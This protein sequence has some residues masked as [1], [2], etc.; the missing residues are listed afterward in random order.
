MYFPDRA[1]LVLVLGALSLCCNADERD[2]CFKSEVEDHVLKQ[3]AVHEPLSTDRETFGFIFRADGLISSAVVRGTRCA[4]REVCEVDTR[5][6]AAVRWRGG[7]LG[8]SNDIGSRG[9]VHRRPP[10]KLP[11]GIR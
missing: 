9:D 2:I 5:R 4:W 1:P 11:R 3:F 6:A 10:R 8:S 7:H